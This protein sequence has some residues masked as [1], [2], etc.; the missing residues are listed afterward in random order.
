MQ[1]HRA[2]TV[3]VSGGGVLSILEGYAADDGIAFLIAGLSAIGNLRNAAFVLSVDNTVRGIVVLR[4]NQICY[5]VDVGE[6]EIR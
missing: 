3:I 4:M 2:A 1:I 5:T 6:C